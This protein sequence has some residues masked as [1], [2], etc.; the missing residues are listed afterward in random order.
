MKNLLIAAVLFAG[1][2]KSAGVDEISKLKDEA[3]ACKDKACG[4]AANKKLD[5]AIEKLGADL[6]GKEPDQATSKKLLD[7]MTQAGECLSKLK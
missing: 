3:C 6:G 4:D 7:A 5:E 1:C 2:S